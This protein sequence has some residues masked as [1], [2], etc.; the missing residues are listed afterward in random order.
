[1]NKSSLE[2]QKSTLREKALAAVFSLSLIANMFA[3]LS[4]SAFVPSGQHSFIATSSTPS[5]QNVTVSNG[6]LKLSVRGEWTSADDYAERAVYLG[7]GSAVAPLRFD[8]KQGSNIVTEL[9]ITNPELE[10][11]ENQTVGSV[12]VPSG[13]TLDNGTWPSG[14][15][16]GAPDAEYSGTWTLSLANGSYTVTTYS[17]TSYRTDIDAATIA[18]D[19]SASVVSTQAAQ[20]L[21]SSADATIQLGQSF[22]PTYAG[23]SGT[24]NWQF[25]V[26]NYTNWNPD[27]GYAGTDLGNNP[28]TDPASAYSSSF[29]PAA[30]G[31]YQFY[32]AKTADG[33]YLVSNSA[34]P[35]TLTVNP[36]VP[37]QP[38]S[39]SCTANPSDVSNNP[40]ITWTSNVSGGTA[41]YQ[42]SWSIYNDVSNYGSPTGTSTSYIVNYSSTG[43][44]AAMLHIV[45]AAGATTSAGC[46]GTISPSTPVTPVSP[47]LVSIAVTTPPNKVSYTVGDA[48]DLSGLVV[49]GTY[50]DGSTAVET[51][52][53]ADVGG[54]NPSATGTQMLTVTFEGKTATFTV[55][56]AAAP[57]VVVPPT[58][59]ISLSTT[60]VTVGDS[61]GVVSTS[62]GGTLTEHGVE[63]CLVGGNCPADASSGNW[64]NVG[65]SNPP[66]NPTDTLIIYPAFTG[67]GTY[68][69]RAYAS[70][71]GGATYAYSAISTVTVNTA[72]GTTGGGGGNQNPTHV[73]QVLPQGSGTVTSVPS[74]IS[75]SSSSGCSATFNTGTAVTLSEVPNAGNVW[76]SWGGD[77]AYA[78]TSTTCSLTLTA[79]MTARALFETAPT[80]TPSNPVASSTPA[81]IPSAPVISGP[82]TGTTTVSY[83]FTASSTDPVG[84]TIKYLFDWNNDGIVDATSSPTLS[85]LSATESNVWTAA[86]LQTFSVVAVNAVGA[87][88]TSTYSILIADATSSSSG[89]GSGTTGGGSTSSGSGSAGGMGTSSG[90]GVHFYSGSHA[91]QTVLEEAA[92]SSPVAN[93]RAS[94]PAVPVVG[95]SVCKAGDY[96]TAYMRQGIDNDPAEVT[97][98]QNFLNQYEGADLDVNGTFDASTTA[99]VMAFQVKYSK[100]V[101]SPWGIDYPTGIVYI[102]TAHE[103]NDIFCSSNPAYTG[104]QPATTTPQFNG[105]VGFNASNSSSTPTFSSNIAGVIG[106]IN[107]GVKDFLKDILW[108]PLLILLLIGTGMWLVLRYIFLKD[109]KDIGKQRIFL[110]GIGVF[111]AGSVLNMANTLFYILAPAAFMGM[112]N[113]TVGMVLGLDLINIV[114][115]LGAT[116]ASLFVFQKQLSSRILLPI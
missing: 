89:S 107:S 83:A 51:I 82:T 48:L 9:Q 40:S 101:L 25:V 52:T 36:A 70:N 63:T 60:T 19:S 46:S 41:P 34:G 73:L 79:D 71:D 111:S 105:A 69:V 49:T 62:T 61:I 84:G 55:T 7:D 8:V 102:T 88:A 38:L 64:V 28:S 93:T 77:C 20:S 106:S 112:T 80:S 56:V 68:D 2:P 39:A 47:T 12:S 6:T 53:A 97:K 95:P 17:G 45:D 27:N 10:R 43:T 30:A 24:G 58:V 14:W 86:G 113:M 92:T 65:A 76:N 16:A 87:T 37:S 32:V 42:Y 98:L 99:A 23:G 75:C 108:Y 4:A 35:Y 21:V 5:V 81:D 13:T 3:P 104:G 78:G 66:S 74:G 109:K 103:I 59:T 22:T 1:M 26:S 33:N 44:K 29:T 96:I 114:L 91:A 110:D 90:G 67:A 85:G 50:S 100:D 57:V 54:F 94:A 11:L 116:L 15:A 31:T 72:S 18:F 115:M